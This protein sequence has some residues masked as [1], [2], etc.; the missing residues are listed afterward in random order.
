LQHPPL[1]RHGR[2]PTITKRDPNLKHILCSA[3]LGVLLAFC[4]PAIAAASSVPSDFWG[5]VPQTT[6]TAAQ[7]QQLKDG[8]VDSIRVPI[9]WGAVEGSEGA[10]PDWSSVDP[11]VKGAAAAGIEVLPFLSGAPDWAVQSVVKTEAERSAWAEFL[12]L[13][14]ARY[15]PDGSLWTANPTLPAQPIRTWQIWNEE[16]F[17]YFVAQPDPADYGKLVEISSAALK[18]ADPGAKLVLG[19]LF[20]RPAEA[21]SKHK[22]PPAYFATDFLAQM[23]RDTPG[24]RSAFSGVALHPYT[25]S[26]RELPREI[27]AVRAVLKANHDAGKSLWIT[28]LGWSSGRP[29]AANGFNSYEK[30]PQGQAKQLSG[31]FQLLRENQ[32]RWR[33]RRVLW[34][35]L[36]DAPG[37][38]NF[39]D[40][41]GL[42][43]PGFVPKPAWGAFEKQTR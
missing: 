15:G 18:G 13:A 32:R 43:G 4:V 34:F 41:S 22:P 21:D 5:V 24:I 9:S 16:N 20:A 6:P 30:G 33:L 28:E 29:E 39:C 10:P 31:A 36:T 12:R 7:F 25:S 42:F 27:E 19:G 8:G 2:G 3:C 38:C 1:L 35:S 37:S 11:M 23:Y 26:Y 40:G 14:V 17:K